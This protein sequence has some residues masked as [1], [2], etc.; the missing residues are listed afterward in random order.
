VG[1]ERAT[2]AALER[3]LKIEIA[4]QDQII[5]EA[6]IIPQQNLAP[7]QNLPAAD[8]QIRAFWGHRWHLRN[9]AGGEMPPAQA[10]DQ[11]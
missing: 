2:P 8:R 11:D 5:R 3:L 1:A 7:Q 10:L 4:K 9:C 6:G